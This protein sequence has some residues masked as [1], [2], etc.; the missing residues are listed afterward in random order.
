ML[1]VS[2]TPIVEKYF[3]KLKDKTLIKA[4]KRAIIEIRKNPDIGQAKTGNLKG[5]YCLDIYYNRTK[6]ELAYRIS[7]LENGCMIV[8]IMAGT[9]E[10]FYNELKQYLK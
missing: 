3:K 8:V 6:Y 5:L 2:Y 4:F 7:K 9:R 1:P 10:N